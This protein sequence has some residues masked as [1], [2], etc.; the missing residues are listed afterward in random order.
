MC[1][2][3][4]C[5][6]T[7]MGLQ[8]KEESRQV[9]RC[10]LQLSTLLA[11]NRCPTEQKFTILTSLAGKPTL[12]IYLSPSH[13]CWD[14]R[15]MQLYLASHLGAEA[16][17]SGPL[18]FAQQA[19]LSMKSYFYIKPSTSKNWACANWIM[20]LYF[21]NWYASQWHIHLNFCCIH[22]LNISLPPT[23]P[24][25]YDDITLKGSIQI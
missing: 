6:G 13:Q 23:L 5:A 14:Y 21:F 22:T 24:N 19:L 20:R 15:C 8:P 7:P 10:L 1:G 2:T 4:A 11:E 3:C 25:L 9:V 16:S 12:R 17:N 18:M